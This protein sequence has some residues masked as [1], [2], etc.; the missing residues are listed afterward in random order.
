MANPKLL[1]SAFVVLAAAG[2]LTG[3]NTMNRLSEVGQAPKMTTIQDPTQSANY[4]PVSL[5]MPNPSAST[6]RA[7]SLWRSGARAF[8]KDQRAAV[9]GDILTVEIAIDDKAQL[10]NTSTRDRA[11]TEDSAITNLLG[12][13]SAL[14]QVLPEAIQPSNVLTLDS[15]TTNSGK[16]TIDRAETINL[17]VAAIV[18]QTL[19]NGNL[20]I[21]GR[22][23]VRVNY[24]VRELQIA[25]IIRPE[26]ITSSNTIT[27]EK[28]AEARIA[29]GGRGHISDFQQPRWGQQ[30]I[31]V[32]FPF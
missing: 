32:L 25:G 12:Y 1:R 9:V 10:N 21:Q 24:E 18:T 20:V 22:Q 5:P 11:N 31:D 7:N 14:A 4:R 27:Y 6:H 2:M 19:P 28:I 17:K 23:E 15:T 16:G 3:C 30:L 26:D 13:E 29:Y 8:F